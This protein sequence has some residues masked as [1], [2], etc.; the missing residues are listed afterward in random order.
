[1]NIQAGSLQSNFQD[2]HGGRLRLNEP[3]IMP[4]HYSNSPQER[5][6]A[7]GIVLLNRAWRPDI[8]IYLTSDVGKVGDMLTALDWIHSKSCS[9][10]LSVL[11]NAVSLA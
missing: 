8:G 11:L 3:I 5:E 1:M 7:S 4:G 6:R 9:R 10:F 2:K